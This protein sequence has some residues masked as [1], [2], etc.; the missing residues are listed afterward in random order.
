MRTETDSEVSN[1][2]THDLVIVLPKEDSV[3]AP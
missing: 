1:I 3:E 2:T